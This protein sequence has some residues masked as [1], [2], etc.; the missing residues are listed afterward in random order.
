MTRD[1]FDIAIL[2]VKVEVACMC[3]F[4]VLFVSSC[5]YIFGC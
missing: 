5:I 2:E 1:V 4:L 3:L